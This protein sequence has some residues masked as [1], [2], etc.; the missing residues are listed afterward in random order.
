MDS[1]AGEASSLFG[2]TDASADP[3]ATAL[4][5]DTHGAPSGQH[6]GHG[7]ETS[8]TQESSVASELFNGNADGVDFFSAAGALGGNVSDQY[9]AYDSTAQATP[10][11]EGTQTTVASTDYPQQYQ[12]QGYQENGWYGADQPAT[13]YAQQSQAY[14]TTAYDAPSQTHPHYA[15]TYPSYTPYGP[16]AS[17][18]TVQ[19]ASTSNAS[20]A[21][22]PYKP[23]V[24]PASAPYALQT[25]SGSASQ[26]SYDPYNHSQ[27]AYDPYKPA[28][29]TESGNDPYRPQ[30][31]TT[32]YSAKSDFRWG[33]L[34]SVVHGTTT[35]TWSCPFGSGGG[36]LSSEDI[37]CLRS[38]L[39]PPK[40]KRVSSH[41]VYPSSPPPGQQSALSPPPRGP[42]RKQTPISSTPVSSGG[43][44]PS[45]PSLQHPPPVQRYASP[46]QSMAYDGMPHAV[47]NGHAS[48][49]DYSVHTDTG[50]PSQTVPP[51]YAPHG[52]HEWDTIPQ[53]DAPTLSP[54]PSVPPP[55]PL[56]AP[57]QAPS[58]LILPSEEGL[59]NAE[60]GF[61]PYTPNYTTGPTVSP[62]TT[63]SHHGSYGPS[64]Y[65]HSRVASPPR[66]V[67]SPSTASSA[68]PNGSTTSPLGHRSVYAPN[69]SAPERTRSPGSAS[70]RSV[71]SVQRQPLEQPH[72]GSLPKSPSVPSRGLTTDSTHKIPA[73]AYDPPLP[74]PRRAASPSTRVSPIPMNRR[75]PSSVASGGYDPYAPTANNRMRSMSNGSVLSSISA[76]LEDPYS[77]SRHVR[78]QTSDSTRSS[79]E[80]V[81]ANAYAPTTAA[82]YDGLAQVL[83]I[84][85]QAQTMYAP[86]PSLVGANDPLGR[87]AARIPVISFGFGGKLVA[88]FHGSSAGGGFDVALASRH[89]SEVKLHTLHKFIPDSALDTSVASY[90]G[91]LF[92]DPGTPTTSLVRT[93]VVT[94]TKTKKARVIKYMEERADELNRGLGYFHSGSLEGR[95]AEGK[96]ILVKLLKVMVENDGRLSGSPSIDAAVRSALTPRAAQ[97]AS[98]TLQLASSISGDIQS[99][100]VAAASPYLSLTASQD[101]TDAI[102][103]THTLQSSHLDK[104]QEFLLR[105][106]RRAASHYASDQKLWAHAMV[107]ASSI[108][109]EAWKEVVTEFVRTELAS[110]P[111]VPGT[112]TK[113]TADG[114]EA[115]RVA[116]SLF[117]GHG[118]ASIQELVT[119]K[120]LAQAVSTLQVPLPSTTSVTPLSAS[121]PGPSE[122]MNV[123]LEVLAKWADTIAM[124]YSSPL[125]FETSS[126]LT[127]LGDQ[128]AANH[129]YEAAHACYLL[130][131]QTSPMGGIGSSSRMVLLG[132]PSPSVSLSFAKDPDPLIFSEV[133]EF[134]MSLTTPAKGQEAFAGLPHLQPY[135]LIRAANLAELGHVQLANRYC[136][137]ISHSLNRNSPYINPTFLEQLKGLN[138]RLVAA[139]QLDKSGSWITSK[140]SK[141][142]LDGIGSWVGGRLTKFIAGEDSPR[143][144]QQSHGQPSQ[145][146][147]G[148]FSQTGSATGLRA[149]AAPQINRA[150]SAMD[151]TRPSLSRKSSPV[152]RVASAN[153]ATTTFADASLYSQALNGHAFGSSSKQSLNGYGTQDDQRPAIGTWWG[154]SDA[155][156]TTPTASSFMPNDESSVQTA[157]SSQFISLMDDYSATPTAYQA[158]RTFSDNPSIDEEDDLGLGNSFSR[159][160]RDR[161]A[162]EDE[163]AP[164]PTKEE[165][166]EPVKNEEKP[167]GSSSGWLSR[168]W[169]RESTPAPV[170]AN[171]G[172]QT[173]FY[174]DKELKRW[175]N[176]NSGAE[177]AKPG[178]P[179]PPPRAQTTS[180][181]KS[182]RA[183]PSGATPPPPPTRPATT[184]P[185]DGPP[186]PPMRI[187]S[188]LVPP[189]SD[190][191]APPTPMSATLPGQGPP[192]ASRS[193]GAAKR[194]ARSRYVDVFAQQQQGS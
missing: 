138:D 26:P 60:H 180:P 56:A 51:Y 117:S 45:A 92:S 99:P 127:A 177:T 24:Q 75:L 114:R 96:F 68:V 25:T 6:A 42:P 35:G 166:K 149:S 29:S 118:S 9:G 34:E 17:S 106:E 158:Q 176:K 140:V 107:I 59:A 126:A 136:E 131:P 167:A 8:H 54:N 191:S 44:A 77:L 145:S 183:L 52:H 115:L 143:P 153:P 155:S 133:A 186:K 39:P 94:Q 63:N 194:P 160:K 90:P 33:S 95:R 129:W 162:S 13:G 4:G 38:P 83:T 48:S 27:P 185:G 152:P 31:A 175:V 142:S 64:P 135:R 2:G 119:P 18:S 105:G 79:F 50:Y 111:Q 112:H 15:S 91:P 36:P 161:Q 7:G 19:T 174:Y 156:A 123:S 14:S 188:N 164:A 78:Q 171:L 100:S 82:T 132:S 170:K 71:K 47:H 28:Q 144:D 40:T 69:H 81:P 72:Q 80:R 184:D 97:P 109:K 49:G 41:V 37:E 148:P 87:T 21:Y 101:P 67:A 187:R 146:F 46:Q 193:R 141:P 150:S 128:L 102:V 139:P 157:T 58:S 147:G 12:G 10:G 165:P 23:A 61:D 22:D 32:S 192:P 154:S 168:L 182:M 137:A 93:A 88:C 151:Y 62:P 73:N 110:K 85:H 98:D 130:S 3:F 172:E 16:A 113:A 159:P 55:P 11:Y 84:P 20:A 76:V 181:G 89:C 189:E 124:I 116:Y 57:Y 86:S 125:T 163:S 74:D 103:A 65:E 5:G 43:Y 1:G 104:I 120:P 169:K 121:F 66:K 70:V 179:P 190:S 178:P 173:S 30:A 53:P 122:P 134:A 108:D